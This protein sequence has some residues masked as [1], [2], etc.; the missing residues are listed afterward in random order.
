MGPS[1]TLRND[2]TG[3]GE[4]GTTQSESTAGS[5]LPNYLRILMLVDA[6]TRFRPFPIVVALL[7]AL[8]V[9]ERSHA[10]NANESAEATVGIGPT[11]GV[12]Q[13]P[14]RC[15]SES[16]C[17]HLR[18]ICVVAFRSMS[19]SSS[20]LLSNCCQAHSCSIARR[21][22]RRQ[23]ETV[24]SQPRSAAIAPS[25]K[26]VK[27]CGHWKRCRYSG[28]SEGIC[29]KSRHAKVVTTENTIARRIER[30]RGIYGGQGRPAGRADRARRARDAIKEWPQS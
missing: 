7:S 21:R 9:P 11:I 3:C 13:L 28:S 30:S 4:P 5:D 29:H 18:P 24:L 2:Q 22:S 26:N 1:G 14:P 10:R 12:L 20:A 17:V 15:V 23:N 27:H 25:Q 16:G 6:P 19:V 8:L